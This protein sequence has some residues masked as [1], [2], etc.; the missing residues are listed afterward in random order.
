MRS[1]SEPAAARVP[2][3]AGSTASGNHEY[4]Q[5]H[6]HLTRSR[7]Q[8]SASNAAAPQWEPRKPWAATLI[9]NQRISFF[10]VGTVGLLLILALFWKELVALYGDR[11]SLCSLSNIR[12]AK[13]LA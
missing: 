8:D 11:K 7:P 2:S 1:T 4:R 12:G 10:L 5:R 6:F 9:S 3:A 13:V